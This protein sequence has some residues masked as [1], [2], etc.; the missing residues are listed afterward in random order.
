MRVASGIVHQRVDAD[1]SFAGLWLDLDAWEIHLALTQAAPDGVAEELQERLPTEIRLQSHR[2]RYSLTEL[3]TLQQ[4]VSDFLRDAGHW[5]EHAVDLGVRV[6]T[7]LVHLNL[8]ETTPPE[9]LAAIAARFGDAP[10]Q[11]ALTTA[12]WIAQ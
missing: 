4:A 11:V 6:K 1:P 3:E 8:Q 10:L 7:N 9:V 12:R 2:F 5:P